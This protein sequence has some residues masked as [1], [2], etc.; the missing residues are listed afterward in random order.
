MGNGACFVDIAKGTVSHRRS[1]SLG[2]LV[3]ALFW[4]MCMSSYAVSVCG[5]CICC[6]F[7][8]LLSLFYYLRSKELRSGFIFA[9]SNKGY[10]AE[11]YM[12][13]RGGK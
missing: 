10:K 1:L 6:A 13:F 4:F 12:N 7:T 9:S 11:Y 3:C 8:L 2:L 5:I